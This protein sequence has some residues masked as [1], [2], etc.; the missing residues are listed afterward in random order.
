M[1]FPILHS[2]YRLPCGT[3]VRVTSNI[4]PITEKFDIKYIFSK[5]VDVEVDI[6]HWMSILPELV[7]DEDITHLALKGYVE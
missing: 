7:E 1:S 2:C 5:R 3:Y 4:H 6:H